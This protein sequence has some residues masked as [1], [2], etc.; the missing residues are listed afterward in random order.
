[1]ETRLEQILKKIQLSKVIDMNYIL[2]FTSIDNK[3]AEVLK[4]RGYFLVQDFIR[5]NY[6][7]IS[8]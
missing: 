5:D 1:M 2:W 3:T 6:Y 7:K 4:N 8:W